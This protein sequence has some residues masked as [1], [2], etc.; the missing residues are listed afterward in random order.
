MFL[1][2]RT[3]IFLSGRKTFY[4]SARYDSKICVRGLVD[5]RLCIISAEQGELSRQVYTNNGEERYGIFGVKNK[6]IYVWL[7]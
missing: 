5:G 4:L 3:S 6:H 2:G 7:R 1:S